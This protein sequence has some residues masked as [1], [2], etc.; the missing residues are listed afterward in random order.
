MELWK[1]RGE[2]NP[3]DLFTKHL[4]ADRINELLNLFGCYSVGGRAEGAP[5]LRKTGDTEPLLTTQAPQIKTAEQMRYTVGEMTEN[6]DGY[7]YPSVR[8]EDEGHPLPDA[9]LHD[10]AVLPH[11][12]P[13]N[14]L[15]MF[16]RVYAAKDPEGGVV[17]A[18]DW[19]EKLAA[20]RGLINASLV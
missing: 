2:V 5:I 16:P 11:M 17:E 18:A 3:A 10:E 6:R 8:I 14:L 12:I 15:M 13:G 7:K 20:E 4:A 1:V 9:F 19:L